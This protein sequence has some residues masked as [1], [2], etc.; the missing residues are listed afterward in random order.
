[1]K[2]IIGMHPSGRSVV[3]EVQEEH[4]YVYETALGNGQESTLYKAKCSARLDSFTS[5]EKQQG[6]DIGKW[7]WREIESMTK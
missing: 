4:L 6:L 2:K 7:K 5:E 3:I 1:M